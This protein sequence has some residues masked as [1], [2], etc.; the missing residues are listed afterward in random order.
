M[1]MI[2]QGSISYWKMLVQGG[3]RSVINGVT[4]GPHNGLK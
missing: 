4:W 2:A 3:P 1:P